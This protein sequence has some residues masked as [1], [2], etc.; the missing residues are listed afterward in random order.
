MHPAAAQQGRLGAHLR[1]RRGGRGAFGGAEQGGLW[2]WRGGFL[3]AARGERRLTKGTSRA[4]QLFYSFFK[5]LVGAEVT[6]E[7]KNDLVV[8]GRLDSVDQYLNLKLTDIQVADEEKFPH[9]LSVKNAFFRGSV[10]RYVHV[11]PAMVKTDLLQD[12][13]RRTQQANVAKANAQ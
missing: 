8:T 9:M 12:A 3:S 11:P 13:S 7:L 4:A 6:V 1:R 2:P 10:V 5:T